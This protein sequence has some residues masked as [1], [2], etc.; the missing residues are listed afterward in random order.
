MAEEKLQELVTEY[1][2]LAKD[3]N[4]DAAALLINALEHSSDNNL[5]SKTKRWGY[6]ISIGAPPLG[7]IFAIWFYFSEKDDGKSAGITCLLLTLVSCF[8]TYFLFKSVIS[9]AGVSTTQI[10]QIKP[11]DIYE[12]TQ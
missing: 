10:Q 4:I 1:A 8:L 5:S 11:K 3:K 9:G 2:D 6:L 7:L 12:I